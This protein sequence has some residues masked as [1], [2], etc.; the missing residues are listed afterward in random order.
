MGVGVGVEVGVGVD[1]AV[2]VGVKVAE[3][4]GDAVGAVAHDPMMYLPTHPDF[5]H[6]YVLHVEPI[7]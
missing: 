6:S 7:F 4:V 2:G 3:G 5:I 1:V